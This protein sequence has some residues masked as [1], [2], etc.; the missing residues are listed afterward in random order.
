MD[1]FDE[2]VG[3]IEP[4]HITIPSVVF[5]HSFVGED[6]YLRRLV[7]RAGLFRSKYF[8]ALFFKLVN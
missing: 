5:L 3:Q 4:N 1:V 8:I 6:K 7:S 2:I